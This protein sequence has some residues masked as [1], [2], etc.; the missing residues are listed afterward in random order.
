MSDRI[1]QSAK[2]LCE[3]FV[4][5][6]ETGKARSRETYTECKALLKLIDGNESTMLLDEEGDNQLGCEDD[7]EKLF[8]A[9]EYSSDQRW[10]AVLESV[11]YDIEYIDAA[12]I[13][14]TRRR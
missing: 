5:K 12:T 10:P 6:V 7:R 3:K 8:S 11:E 13:R 4:K 14:L 9:P 1:I 2:A